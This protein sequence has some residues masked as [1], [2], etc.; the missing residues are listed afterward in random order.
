MGVLVIFKSLS[1][2]RTGIM[3]FINFGTEA[4]VE[5]QSQTVGPIC[6]AARQV[7]VLYMMIFGAS[8]RGSFWVPEVKGQGRR[9]IY[10]KW[11]RVGC[12]L[13]KC[14]CRVIARIE[15]VAGAKYSYPYT[16]AR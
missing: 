7:N 11:V 12:A 6:I 3:V 16:H 14:R 15:S 4:I 9:A 13:S 2:T 10:R 1:H 8:R 5:R